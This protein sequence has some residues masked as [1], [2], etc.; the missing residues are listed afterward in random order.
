MP[1]SD[2]CRE[3]YGKVKIIRQKEKA[4]RRETQEVEGGR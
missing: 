2:L 1:L 3:K 4:D